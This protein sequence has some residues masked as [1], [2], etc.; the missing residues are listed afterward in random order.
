MIKNLE[1]SSWCQKSASPELFSLFSF[2]YVVASFNSFSY[3][4]LNPFQMIIIIKV[5]ISIEGQPSEYLH[6]PI[7]IL[8]PCCCPF[9]LS[10]FSKT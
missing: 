9:S 8:T 7:D 5:C 2:Q 3:P 10:L 6:S 1:L 4:I